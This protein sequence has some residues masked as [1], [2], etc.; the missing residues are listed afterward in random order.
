MHALSQFTLAIEVSN[1][2]VGPGDSTAS[3]KAPRAGVALG[4]RRSGAA[5]IEC[6]GLRWLNPASRHDDALMPAID[7]LCREAGVAPRDLGRI[8][9]SI[10]PGGY[11]STRIGVTVAKMIAFATRA[12]CVPVPTAVAVAH[13]MPADAAAPCRVCLA[14]KRDTA[15]CHDFSAAP[16]RTPLNDGRLLPLDQITR[17]T[18]ELLIAEPALVAMLP[19]PPAARIIEPVFDPRGVL[20]ASASAVDVDPQQLVPLYPREPEAVTKWRELHPR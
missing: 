17:A 1:P 6:I 10:G 7:E 8:A 2:G 15:W 12:R 13:N 3:A 14:W 20:N 5:L 11:T 18:P 19:A 16:A 4:R 9:V